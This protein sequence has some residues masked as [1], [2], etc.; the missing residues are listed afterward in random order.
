MGLRVSKFHL[1]LFSIFVFVLLPLFCKKL[2]VNKVALICLLATQPF[3]FSR[4]FKSDWIMCCGS[5]WSLVALI[6]YT[7]LLL[8]TAVDLVTPSALC[9]HK[10][11]SSPLLP[12]LHCRPPASCSPPGLMLMEGEENKSGKKH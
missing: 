5:S 7:R 4:V 2:S 6:R 3:L 9:T 10:R 8:I 11:M 12:P 1:L